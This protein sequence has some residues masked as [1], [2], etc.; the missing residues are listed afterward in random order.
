MDEYGPEHEESFRR[1]LAAQS[2]LWET[3]KYSDLTVTCCGHKWHVHR[4]ILC[5][6]STFFAAACDGDF[7]VREIVYISCTGKALVWLD[8]RDKSRNNAFTI[9]R[10]WNR[11]ELSYLLKDEYLKREYLKTCITSS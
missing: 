11:H 7:Q 3:G 6:R 1:S 8:G 4:N 9:A 5:L 10:S 2:K